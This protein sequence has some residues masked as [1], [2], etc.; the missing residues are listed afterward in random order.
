M[1]QPASPTADIHEQATLWYIRL[2]EPSADDSLRDAHRQWLE[3]DPLHARA[4]DET[5]RLWG[6]LGEPV[7]RVRAEERACSMARRSRRNI[8]KP[9]A[10]AACLVAMLAS[11]A[12]WQRGALD[13]LRSDYHTAIGARQNIELDDGS[14]I[15]LNTHSAIDVDFDGAQRHI[16][17]LRGEAWFEVNKDAQRPFVVDVPH[18]RITVTGTRFNV[19]LDD[20]EAIVSLSQGRVELDSGT[21]HAV[22]EPSQQ[23]RLSQNGISALTSFDSQATTAWRQGQLVFYRTPLKQVIAELDRYHRG[24]VF[25]KGETLANLPVSGVFATDAPEAVLQAIQDTLEV[26]VLHLGLGIVILR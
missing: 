15:E 2:R 1:T 12:L 22:L 13:D 5:V 20:D 25:I 26:K 7:A 18:G 23:S 14:R 19:R 24:H 3:A 8:L 4:F 10:A 11:G 21:G 16:R 17:L 6:Q 9:L